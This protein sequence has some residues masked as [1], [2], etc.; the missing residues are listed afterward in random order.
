MQDTDP[1]RQGKGDEKAPP[2]LFQR[3]MKSKVVRRWK[4]G[5]KTLCKA[6]PGTPRR[7]V[8]RWPLFSSSVLAPPCRVENREAEPFCNSPRSLARRWQSS[9]HTPHSETPHR[10]GFYENFQL[11]SDCALRSEAGVAGMAVSTPSHLGEAAGGIRFMSG[12]SPF[13]CTRLAC[14]P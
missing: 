14:P 2:I 1:S 11:A 7:E 8:L 10:F 13:S 5:R 9:V 4:G 3:R 6:P 12:L